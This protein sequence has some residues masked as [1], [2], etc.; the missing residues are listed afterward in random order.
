MEFPPFCANK[1]NGSNNPISTAIKSNLTFFIFP[2]RLLAYFLSL[3][4]YPA[5]D[6]ELVGNPA[7]MAAIKIEKKK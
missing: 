7:A 1:P 6:A 4:E 5:G 2:D 3:N